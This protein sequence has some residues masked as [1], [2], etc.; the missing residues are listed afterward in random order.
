M[1]YKER[2]QK[3][4]EKLQLIIK[5]VRELG[6]EEKYSDLIIY[7]QNYLEDAKHFYEQ[8][9]YFTCFGAA[10]YAYGFMDSILLLEGKHDENII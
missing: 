10:N 9:D 7:A 5:K 4:I 6:F 8:E 2:A 1:D 3:D